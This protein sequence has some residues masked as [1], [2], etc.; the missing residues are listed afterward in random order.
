MRKTIFII[1]SLIVVLV[2]AIFFLKKAQAPQPSPTPNVSEVP[3]TPRPMSS[4]LDYSTLP[5]KATCALQGMIRYITPTTYNNGD[6]LLTYRGVDHPGRNIFW[7][8]SPND[9]VDL[10]PDIFT[11]LALPDGSSLLSITL[12]ERPIA[13]RYVVTASMQYGRLVDGNVKVSVT[14]CTG[15]TTIILP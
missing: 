7:K 3:V 11:Q 4:T 1:I 12:P 9:D 2:L 5:D 14:P 15:A 10:G 6:A 8:V 13:R